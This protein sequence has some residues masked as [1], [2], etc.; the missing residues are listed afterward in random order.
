MMHGLTNHHE[1]YTEHYFAELLAGDLKDTLEG[2][3]SVALEHPDSEELREPPARLRGLR[4]SYFRSVEKLQRSSEEEETIAETQRTFLQSL[5]PI[6][7]YSLQPSWRALG[8]RKEAIRIPLLG[9]VTTQSGAPALWLIEALPPSASDDDLASDPLGLA[10]R[11]I[12]YA[13]DPQ[14]DAPQLPG[15]P[16]AEDRSW[17]DILSKE[18]YGL[19]RSARNLQPERRSH[20]PDY[21]RSPPSRLHLPGRWPLTAR[22]SR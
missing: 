19:L 6:L 21:R 2:W 18:V 14:H 4:Q 9:E 15:T 13:D 3:K 22:R 10:P 11:T 1:Y 17:A 8:E 12:Q 20:L 7:G 16:P 5:I